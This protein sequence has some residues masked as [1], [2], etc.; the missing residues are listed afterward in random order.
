MLKKN[1]KR[2]KNFTVHF[3]LVEIKRQQPL[4]FN[5]ELGVCGFSKVLN[6]L[7]RQQHWNLFCVV[8][9][10]YNIYYNIHSL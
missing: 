4:S 10:K 3:T 2:W 7:E 6:T 1:V 8:I 9:K 5:I